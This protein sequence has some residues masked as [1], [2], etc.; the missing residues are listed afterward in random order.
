MVA[1][2]VIVGVVVLLVPILVPAPKYVTQ[3]LKYPKHVY[4]IYFLRCY[5]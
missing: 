3:L 4:N 2:D 5:S 1:V